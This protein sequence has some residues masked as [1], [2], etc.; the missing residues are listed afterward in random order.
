M[1]R[2]FPIRLKLTVAALAPLVAAIAVCSLTGLWLIDSRI[3]AQAQEKV[4]TDLNSAREVYRNEVAHVADV[5]KLAA[6]AL[7]AGAATAILPS[8]AADEKLDFLAVTDSSGRVVYRTGGEPGGAGPTPAQRALRG[9]V[10]AGTT[11]IPPE[12]LAREGAGLSARAVITAI[13]TPRAREGGAAEERAG[14]AIVAAAPL[15]SRDGRVTGALYGGVL[16]NNNNS[17][18]DSIKR[19]VYEGVKFEG[20]EAGTA[21]IFLGDLRIATNVPAPGGGRAIGTRLSKEVYDRVLL[22]REKWV[23]RAFVVDDWYLTAYEPILDLE[24][25]AVGSLYVGMLERPYGELKI[26][27]GVIFGGVLLVGTLI[28]LAIS[29]FAGKRLATPIRELETLARRVAAGERDVRIEVASRDEIGDLGAEFNQMTRS[30]AQREEEIRELNRDLEKKV[31]ERTAE[32][33]KTREELVRAEKLAAVGM[34]AAGVAHEINNPMAIIRGNAELIRMGQPGDADEAET[35]IKQVGRVTRIVD[36]LLRFA[37][38]EPKRIGGGVELDRLLDEVLAGIGHQVPVEGIEFRRRYYPA[39][40]P[41]AADGDQ[42]RQVFTNLILNAVQAMPGG[43]RVTVT[44]S[45]SPEDECVVTVEDNGA[46]IGEESLARIF[47][48][49][50]TTKPQGTGLGL[51][52]SYGIVRDHGGRIEAAAAEGGGTLFKVTLPARPDPGRESG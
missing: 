15:R 50:F 43:G 13:P 8:L 22:A 3:T 7:P 42:L 10:A 20:R 32:L 24:G 1:P 14:M 12:A 27:I 21:T 2:R 35:I 40:P 28:G 37:R 30:L 11:V 45:V 47:D 23:G 39:L 29:G 5:V 16:L 4:R 48:P 25:K 17:L 51:S 38:Q 41:L 31:E 19:I 44:T 6:A 36:N 9:E 49:F 34:L 26:R 33:E 52:V 18:V 46:G